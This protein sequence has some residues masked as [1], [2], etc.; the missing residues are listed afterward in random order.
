M[1]K[2]LL[3]V[4]ALCSTLSI[5]AGVDLT[6]ATELQMG[7]NS[8]STTA[9]SDTCYFKYTATKDVALQLTPA[10]GDGYS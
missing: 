6:N 10:S 7:E 3:F 4:V 9:T 5:W 2:T 1:K 8:K